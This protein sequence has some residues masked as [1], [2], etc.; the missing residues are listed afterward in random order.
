MDYAY[1]IGRSLFVFLLGRVVMPLLYAIRL[2]PFRFLSV[3]G[4][5]NETD[6]SSE[7]EERFLPLLS[8]DRKSQFVFAERQ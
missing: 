2:R 8:S 3:W 4:K 6:R 5:T 1:F 7:F